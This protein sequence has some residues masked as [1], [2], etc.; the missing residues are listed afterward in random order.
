MWKRQLTIGIV[1]ALLIAGAAAYVATGLRL[2]SAYQSAYARYDTVC[3]NLVT[4]NPPAVVYTAFYTNQPTFVNL[5]YR[6]P[7]PQALRISLSIPLL[8]QVQTIQVNAAPG[9][10]QV[11]M[12]PPLL[13]NGVLDALVGQRERDGE[14]DL[15]V[16]GPRGSLCDTTIPVV[17]KSRQI[18]HWFDSAHGSNARYL[19]GWVTP[20]DPV[21]IRLIDRTA[22]WLENH[23]NPPD[24]NGV[25]ALAGYNQGRATPDA[26]RQQV[27][28]IFD[29]LQFVYHLHYAEDN[30]PYDRDAEQ[31][32]QLPRDVLPSG[33]LSGPPPTAMCVET[34]AIMASAVERLGMRPYFIIVPGH[35]FLGVA[36]GTSPS[37]PI[38]YWETSYLGSGVYGSQANF[39][40]DHT[41]YPTYASQREILAT[42]DVEAER[43][44][45]V[46]PIP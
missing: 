44:Q 12:Q 40:A 27:D 33:A 29:T 42:V 4:W 19:A 35:A 17:L 36:L 1:I 15:S 6:S 38:D 31:L 26:V 8:T 41:E 30:V 5:R 46:E 23:P 22:S 43:T 34:T 32:I 25:T 3:G 21:I 18:M 39:Y 7:T 10:Q 2:Y 20:D 37:A 9:F 24:Y 13:N 14:I 28:A 16:Q 45:G 11:A